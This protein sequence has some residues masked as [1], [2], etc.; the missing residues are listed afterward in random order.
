[1]NWYFSFIFHR[2]AQ[3][4][5]PNTF[6]IFMLR[7]L[8]IFLTR[9][10]WPL[11]HVELELV[12]WRVP[13][14]KQELLKWRVP[15]EEQ[16]LSTLP[17]NLW[18]PQVFSGVRVVLSLASCMVFCRSWFVPFSFFIWPLYCLSFYDLRLLIMMIPLVSSNFSYLILVIQSR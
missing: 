10:T 7:V 3:T 9:L 18:L 15:H 14:V 2:L 8:T 4:V 5:S 6:H 12:T 17:E 11:S 1:M 16:E 13:D